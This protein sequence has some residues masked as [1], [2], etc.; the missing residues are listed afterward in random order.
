MLLSL[1][2]SPTPDDLADARRAASRLERVGR[3]L[4]HVLQEELN[5]DS[6][7]LAAPGVPGTEVGG[8]SPSAPATLAYTSAGNTTAGEE[9]ENSETI[10]SDDEV[11]YQEGIS[12]GDDE[13]DDDD[14]DDDDNYSGRYS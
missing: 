12:E 6:D 11:V 1:V 5:R 3:E 4:Q 2:V 14:Y 9:D 7:S 13:F 10:E 8:D